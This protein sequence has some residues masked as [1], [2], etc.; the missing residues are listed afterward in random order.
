MHAVLKGITRDQ[1]DGRHASNHIQVVYAPDYAA[2]GFGVTGES[3]RNARIGKWK[4]AFAE[5]LNEHMESTAG[6]IAGTL[7]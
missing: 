7:P 6:A 3:V 4:L 2:A 5:I 1:M